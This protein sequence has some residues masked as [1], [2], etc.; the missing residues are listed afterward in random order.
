MSRNGSLPQWEGQEDE[1]MNHMNPTT[2]PKPASFLSKLDAF[3]LATHRASTWI[4]TGAS[5]ILVGGYAA[6]STLPA[7]RGLDVTPDHGE[8]QHPVPAPV[9]PLPSD[10]DMIASAQ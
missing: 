1:D 9:G 6:C 7:H 4:S 10:A 8:L 3:L 5:L 2:S